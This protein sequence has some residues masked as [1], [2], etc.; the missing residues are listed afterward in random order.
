VLCDVIVTCRSDLTC[1]VFVELIAAC[2]LTGGWALQG[3]R[4]CRWCLLV[5]RCW[6][7]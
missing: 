5:S 2:V 1:I 6:Y 4:K 3:R 7:V